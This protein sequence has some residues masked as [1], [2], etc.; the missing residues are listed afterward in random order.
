MRRTRSE[1]YALLLEQFE[2]Y[3]VNAAGV[4]P[5]TRRY[6]AV[7]DEFWDGQRVGAR[8]ALRETFDEAFEILG[9]AVLDG[10]SPDGVYDL[11]T[12]EKTDVR[13]S[14]PVVTPVNAPSGYNLL[15]GV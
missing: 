11:D 12:S 1:T 14:R 10:Y 15:E 13:V 7:A 8:I 6:V 2:L 5:E 9:D 4:D 3:T